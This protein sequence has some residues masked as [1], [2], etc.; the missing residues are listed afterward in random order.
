MGEAGLE[1][2]EIY[3]GRAR[4]AQKRRAIDF[5]RTVRAD[6]ELDFARA[7]CAHHGKA[8]AG[9]QPRRRPRGA[10]RLLRR[11]QAILNGEIPAQRAGIIADFAARQ[12]AEFQLVAVAQP[13]LRGNTLGS[14]SPPMRESASNT[15]WR[16]Y[17]NVAS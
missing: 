14:R 5:E 12:Q 7:I 13:V 17:S 11:E 10:Q 16:L 8:G 9:A 6:G 3:A 2:T 15:I 4:R 1:M